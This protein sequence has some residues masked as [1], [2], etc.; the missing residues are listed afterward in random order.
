MRESFE[1]LVRYP[2]AASGLIALALVTSCAPDARSPAKPSTATLFFSNVELAPGRTFPSP[3]VRGT[4]NG[5]ETVFI[6]DTGAQVSVVDAKLATDAALRVVAG[7]AAQD[8][9]GAAV[10]MAKTEAPNIAVDGLG[11][12]PNRMTAVI[13]IPELLTK[14]GIGA[15]LS[16]Q[17]IASDGHRVVLDL[18]RREL[19]IDDASVTS[20]VSERVFDLGPLQVCRYDDKGFGAASL[21]AKAEID[22]VPTTV[23]LDTG[24]SNTFVVADSAIG[25]KLTQ[26]P[27]GDRKKSMS[28]AGEIETARFPSIPAKLGELDITGPLMT[29]PGARSGACG[30]EGRIGIDRLR[31]CMIVVS[32]RDAWGTCTKAAAN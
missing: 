24:A 25:K 27:D 32:P 23:E 7:G 28:A 30:Y 14:L 26:R 22:G 12:L 21:I 15:I 9:S 18:A 20:V 31:T 6:V 2:G 17:M 5:H 16:P 1:A 11:P 3:L 4:V 19:R 8:P 13:A 10:A 29:M